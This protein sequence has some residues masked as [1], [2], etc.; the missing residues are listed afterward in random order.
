[1]IV[2]VGGE[3]WTLGAIV[4][5][6]GDRIVAINHTPGGAPIGWGA[7]SNGD[8]GGTADVACQMVDGKP[9]LVTAQSTV[10]PDGRHWQ[11]WVYA[12]EGARL[13][14]RKSDTGVIAAGAPAPPGVPLK[15][16]IECGQ[17]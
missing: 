14:L 5:L 12:L 7:H 8:P 15:N 13:V 10:E 4:V 1:V 6:D 9:S 16:S 17:P 2:T 3:T 11:R